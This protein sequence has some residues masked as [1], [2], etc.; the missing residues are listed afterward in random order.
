MLT[1]Q[2]LSSAI[3][4]CALASA[5]NAALFSISTTAPTVD[6]ADIAQLGQTDADWDTSVIWG[7]RPARG[8]TFTTGSETAGY[9]LNAFTLKSAFAQGG[10][11]TYSLRVS[12]L[13]GSDLTVFATDSVQTATNVAVDDYVSFTFDSPVVLAPNTLYAIDVVRAGS[14]W[15]SYRNTDDNA[16]AGGTAYSSGDKGVPELT[17]NTHGHDRLFHLDIAAVPEPGSMALLG[18]GVL[19][20][21]RR[22]R[23]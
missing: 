18:L 12:T 9:A 21:A 5:S 23:G 11:G 22:R 2:R 4:C 8:Q 3:A 16:Y 13:S 7:D 1:R 10:N 17:I 14:G 15:H 6:G 20:I 19:L